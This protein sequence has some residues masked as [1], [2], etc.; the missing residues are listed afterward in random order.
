MKINNLLK[1]VILAVILG[2]FILP[3]N[4]EEKNTEY[5]FYTGKF[6]FSD[7]GKATSLIGIQH[8][9]E[10]LNRD[11][12]LGNISPVTGVMFM[13]NSAS[14]VYTGIQAQYKVGKL[15]FNPS[16]TPGLYGEGNGKNLGHIVEF[17]S[18]LQL[19]VDLFE[20]SEFGLKYNHISNANLGDKNPGAN[21]YMLNFLKRF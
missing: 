11:T 10:E 6:D 12:F 8:Q 14:Y 16:F 13:Q 19:T 20:N 18:E 17:K 4:S 9:N 1:K 21:S 5:S 3:V 7:E 2:A 15:N